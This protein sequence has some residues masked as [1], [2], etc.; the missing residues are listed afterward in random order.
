MYI[1]KRQMGIELKED[2]KNYNFFESA[3]TCI[4]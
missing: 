1:A 2:K 3:E 4:D